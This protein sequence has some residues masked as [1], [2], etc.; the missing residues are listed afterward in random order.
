[1]TEEKKKQ[2]KSLKQCLSEGKGR[3]DLLYN[4]KGLP[5]FIAHV[6]SKCDRNK[7]RVFCHKIW[8]VSECCGR[9]L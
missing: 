4:G 9:S 7:D 2:R 8:L 3:C 1:M 6:A 5:W